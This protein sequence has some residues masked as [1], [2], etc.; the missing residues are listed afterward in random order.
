MRSLYGI[1]RNSKSKGTKLLVLLLLAGARNDRGYVRLG[2]PLLCE[3]SRMGE[4]T[5]REAL[6]ALSES[7][8]IMRVEKGGGK[9]KATTYR[10]MVLDEDGDVPRLPD[11]YRPS[12][13][14]WRIE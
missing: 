7:G 10:I 9:A 1:A 14:A 11:D 8:E 3:M 12:E 2:V 5:V 6:S 13:R 4:Q